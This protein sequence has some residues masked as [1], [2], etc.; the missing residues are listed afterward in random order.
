[1]PLSVDIRRRLQEESDAGAVKLILQF[2]GLPPE[3]LT[4]MVKPHVAPLFEQV[5]DCPVSTSCAVPLV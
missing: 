5:S 1:V 2:W 3:P 4:V